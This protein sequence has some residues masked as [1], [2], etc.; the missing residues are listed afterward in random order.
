MIRFLY[1]SIAFFPRKA[2]GL[3]AIVR[4]RILV[5]VV[6]KGTRCPLSVELK[7]PE[8]LSIGR[9]V[10][11]GPGCTIG[12]Y[13]EVKIDDFV[14]IS[15]GATIESAGLDLVGELPYR[16]VGKPISIGRGAWLGARC[17]ILGG[18]TIG[19]GA[20]IGAGAVI[21]KDVPEGAIVVGA[22]VRVLMNKN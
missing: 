8:N 1:R 20:V 9:N 17:M 15:K 6:G 16:H 18:V 12:C 5:P 10:A 21:A 2:L 11:I 13:A 7:C 19:E 3:L 4:L 14:R 22:P